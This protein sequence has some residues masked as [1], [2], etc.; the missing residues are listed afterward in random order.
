MKEGKEKSE[1][2]EW[3]D[4]VENLEGEVE[5]VVKVDKGR[6]Q[7]KL[8]GLSKGAWYDVR[9]Q[10]SNSLG[11]SEQERKVIKTNISPGESRIHFTHLL[12]LDV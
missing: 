1:S 9:I 8:S 11:D 10:A 5:K 4:H 6:T 2:S 12:L 7:H 3:A